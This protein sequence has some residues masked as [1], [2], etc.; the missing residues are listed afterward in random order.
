M[1][2]NDKEISFN[3]YFYL[4]KKVYIAGLPPIYFIYVF[5]GLSLVFIVSRIA[6]IILLLIVLRVIA[7]LRGEFKKG[8]PDYLTSYKI[9]KH[10]P[11]VLEDESRVFKGLIKKTDNGD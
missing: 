8:N 7:K 9:K 10:A 2:L 4:S 1:I 5:A 11:K 3:T 6:G